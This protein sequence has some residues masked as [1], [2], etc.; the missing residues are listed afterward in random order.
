MDEKHQSRKKFGAKS[1][2]SAMLSRALAM[3]N[4][5]EPSITF[6]DADVL[7]SEGSFD[8]TK[9]EKARVMKNY[10]GLPPYAT[11]YSPQ[12]IVYQSRGGVKYDDE[13]TESKST[14]EN[15]NTEGSI[16]GFDTG[17]NDES[18]KAGTNHAAQRKVAHS[19]LSM[20]S[21]DSMSNY[22]L[23]KVGVEAVCRF[24]VESADPEV[25]FICSSCLQKASQKVDNC[26]ILI[27]KQVMQ[28]INVL[29]E[30]RD[31]KIQLMC[32]QILCN[33]SQVLGN[34]E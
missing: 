2:K 7:R 20:A 23:H 26:K 4:K 15:T 5:K 12:A 1:Q 3:Q 28:S 21:T 11:Q 18:T 19:L 14:F 24:L 29:I 27:D 6:S 16:I 17:S 10:F 31:D 9:T 8:G 33:L 22:F 13:E 32:T 25:L 30:N 34:H